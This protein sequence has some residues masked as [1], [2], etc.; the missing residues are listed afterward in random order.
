MNTNKL[1]VG[2]VSTTAFFHSA[3]YSCCYLLFNH[4]VYYLSFIPHW[5]EVRL[6]SQLKMNDGHPVC[7]YLNFFNL[8]LT[9]DIFN[10]SLF[11]G[12]CGTKFCTNCNPSLNT[13]H[14][15]YIWLKRI[16]GKC[17][18]YIWIGRVTTQS[19]QSHFTFVQHTC[20]TIRT[21]QKEKKKKVR[22][23]NLGVHPKSS[24]WSKVQLPY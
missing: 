8:V 5:L 20:V 3:P 11:H 14:F 1:L 19:P 2:V 21:P 23:T 17:P 15:F 12:K 9:L 4:M 6:Y 24:S 22:T 13:I 16:V 18:L 10:G 7:F